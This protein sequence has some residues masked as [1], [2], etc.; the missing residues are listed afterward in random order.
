MSRTIFASAM[1]VLVLAAAFAPN[2]ASAKG[3]SDGSSKRERDA[4][5][6][7]PSQRPYHVDMGSVCSPVPVLV[8][9]YGAGPAYVWVTN[10]DCD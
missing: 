3:G 4:V 2:A 8:R 5:A 1:A 7:W 10:K 6:L 9:N